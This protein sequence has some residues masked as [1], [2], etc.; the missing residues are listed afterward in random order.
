MS[1]VATIETIHG[2]NNIRVS[3]EHCNGIH[4][5]LIAKLSTQGNWQALSE[6][7]FRECIIFL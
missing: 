6:Q 2:N 5:L 4:P 7:E 1:Q 3:Y